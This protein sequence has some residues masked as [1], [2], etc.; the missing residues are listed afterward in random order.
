MSAQL[1]SIIIPVFQECAILDLFLSSLWQT[2][3]VPSQVVLLN[4]GSGTSIDGLIEKYVRSAPPLVNVERRSWLPS[5]GGA[6]SLNAGLEIATG[7]VIVF[8]DSDLMLIAGWQR[9]LLDAVAQ[10]GIGSA[11]A[12]LIYPQSG[13]VQHCGI[14]FSEDIGR[15]LFLNASP[16]DVPKNIFAVQAVVFALCAIRRSV[17]DAIGPIDEQYFNGYE[18][19]DYQMRIARQG[20]RIVV[21]PN[22]KAHHWER[23][24]GPNRAVNR[25]RNLGRFWRQWGHA[26]RSDLAAYLVKRLAEVSGED[27]VFQGI[28]LCRDRP[29]AWQIW[30][31]LEDA[32]GITRIVDLSYLSGIENE[33]WLPRVLGVDG[34]RTTSRL[35]FLTDN[36]VQLLGNRYWIQLRKVIRHD[37]IIIDLYANAVPLQCLEMSC[38]PGTKMR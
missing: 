15:H 9:A 23:G 3:E 27:A 24:N 1:C 6:R 4:D 20:L 13:G 2:V 32:V 21:E 22:A 34:H 36:F 28:D 30:K 17:I 38:W 16:D 18:D 25:K 29:S 5:R 33:I 14:A 37:D 31:A 10:P 11:G 8:A 7:D 35:L 19:L 12:L 26:I